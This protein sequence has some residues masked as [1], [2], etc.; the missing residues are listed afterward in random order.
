VVLA[1]GESFETEWTVKNTGADTWRETDVDF[2][3]SSGTDIHNRDILDLPGSVGAD[4]E[5]TLTVPM[6]APGISG[7]YTSTWVLSMKKDVSCDLFIT[8]RRPHVVDDEFNLKARA[9]VAWV[10]DVHM[11]ADLTQGRAVRID[12]FE[13]LYCYEVWCNRCGVIKHY[14]YPGNAS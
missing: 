2:K 7:S 3:F 14:Y 12:T 9:R 13:W 4:G 8:S 1:P 6:V 5:V 11:G 10:H